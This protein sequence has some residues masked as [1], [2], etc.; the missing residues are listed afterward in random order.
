MCTIMVQ[1]IIW[2]KI[3]SNLKNNILGAKFFKRNVRPLNQKF[4]SKIITKPV[5]TDNERGG[6]N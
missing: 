5:N 6:E 4:F 2:E 3:K 1:K